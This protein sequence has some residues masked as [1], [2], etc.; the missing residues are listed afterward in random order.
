MDNKKREH[1]WKYLKMLQTEHKY[2]TKSYD[3]IC[4]KGHLCKQEAG[5]FHPRFQMNTHEIHEPKSDGLSRKDKT[6]VCYYRSQN[7]C[8]WLYLNIVNVLNII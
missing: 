8:R 1:G 4:S 3:N 6:C 7:V 5:G 2:I